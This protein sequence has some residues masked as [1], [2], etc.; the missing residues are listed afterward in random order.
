MNSSK[1]LVLPILM[2]VVGI[3]WLLTTLGVFPGVDWVWSLGLAAAG[4]LVLTVGGFDKA[5]V[6]VGPFLLSASVLSVF[7]QLG[8]LTD[9]VEGPV[10]LI[11]G[12][13]FALVAR[14]SSIPVPAW[15]AE[16]DEVTPGSGSEDSAES[17]SQKND[18]SSIPAGL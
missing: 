15:Y 2:I 6:V 17:S 13:L 1:S 4:T 16:A 3:G 18:K 11:L 5:T 8:H 10:L 9:E 14:H 12:G 7:R